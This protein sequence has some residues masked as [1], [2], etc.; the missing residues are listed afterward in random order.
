MYN[1]NESDMLD[2]DALKPKRSR[3]LDCD[4][5]P[6][7]NVW[8]RNCTSEPLIGFNIMYNSLCT[9]HAVK[10]MKDGRDGWPVECVR[11]I[12]DERNHAQ[13]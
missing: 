13:K 5:S 8:Y 10:E 2:G 1:I 12:I 7:W 11:L 4:N 9:N 6:V 3:C